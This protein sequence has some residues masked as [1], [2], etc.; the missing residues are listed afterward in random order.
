[1]NVSVRRREVLGVLA[2]VVA[3]ACERPVARPAPSAPTAKPP[4]APPKPPKIARSIEILDWKFPTEFGSE[5]RCVVL[6]PRPIPVGQR[7]PVVVALH[8]LGEATDAESG[9]FG[10]ARR[11]DLDKTMPRLFDDLPIAGD[12]F[13]GFVTPERLV[14]VNA[15]LEQHP[16]AGVIVACPYMPSF[17]GGGAMSFETY[18]QWMGD[19]L[20]PRLRAELPV[21]PDAKATGIDGVSLGGWC[22][23]RVGL[24]RPDLFGAIG[25]L[26]PAIADASMVDHAMALLQQKLGGRP[27]QIV[28]STEDYFRETCTQLHQRLTAKGIAHAFRVTPGPHDYPWNKGAGGVE[29]LL[30][31]DRALRG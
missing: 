10:W 4:E 12:V 21:L 1:M 7:L 8:G 17:V 18:A 6:V 15:G 20:L 26:Q 24:H 19:R 29:M 5:K 9:A 16:F 23:L 25:T 14:E 31:H 2:G 28:T 11:Y 27:L 30:F 13:G 22:A 3:S